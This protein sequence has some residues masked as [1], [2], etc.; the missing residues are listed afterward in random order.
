MGSQLVNKLSAFYGIRSSII[1]F[2]TAYHPSLFW[3][4]SI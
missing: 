4:K 3:A 2:T 1:A